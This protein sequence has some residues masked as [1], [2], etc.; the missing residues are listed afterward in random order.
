[1]FGNRAELQRLHAKTLLGLATA[2]TNVVE[3][4]E[5][6]AT[7]AVRKLHATLVARGLPAS[8]GDVDEGY[9]L[10]ITLTA[11]NGDRIDVE[12]DEFVDGDPR[13]R[14][15]R[16]LATRDANL[17]RLGWRV[18]RVPGWQAYLDPDAI[19][20]QVRRLTALQS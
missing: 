10:A 18:M 3:R 15:Q 5:N 2:A 9:R 17:Q 7:T 11:L 20:D 6:E 14:K 16:Q 13:G 19:A 1:V 4:S 12:V 8:L